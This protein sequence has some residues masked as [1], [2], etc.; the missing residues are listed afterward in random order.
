LGPVK[1]PVYVFIDE[2]QRLPN[3]GLFLKG[4]HDLG[5]PIKLFVSGSSA[6]E[7]RSKIRETLTGR[8]R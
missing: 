4:V 7:I 2:V 6:L 8:K 3:P 5:L 1:R